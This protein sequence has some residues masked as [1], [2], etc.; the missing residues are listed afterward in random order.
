MLV[1][2]CF[3][4]YVCVCVCVCVCDWARVCVGVCVVSFVCAFVWLHM[5]L[6]WCARMGLP[7]DLS[8]C[9]PLCLSA[10]ISV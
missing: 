6:C 3:Y 2:V 7:V 4:A 5:W 10:N 8:V 1:D 9:M